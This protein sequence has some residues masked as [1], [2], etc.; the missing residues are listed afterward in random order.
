MLALNADATVH[1]ILVQ[2]PLPTHMNEQKILSKIAVHKDVD[3]FLPYNVG[4][5]A[6]TGAT[7][8]SVSCTPAGVM[9]LLK[10]SG[11]VLP[12]KRAVVLG[13]SNIVG[14]PL[15]LLL[16][17]ADCTVTVC[18]SKTK[19]VAGRC[20]EADVLCAAVGK[21]CFVQADWIKPGAVVIDVG[22]NSVGGGVVGAAWD[23]E[24][25]SSC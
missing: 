3:G 7:P 15:A 20:R 21:P 1:G 12:G 5:L 10:R 23:V 11:V 18:H 24:W 8:Y 16:T 13:R 25:G 2:L 22:I 19:D 14:T 6:I 9:E 4:C 17:K